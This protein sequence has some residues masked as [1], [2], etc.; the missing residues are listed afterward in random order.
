LAGEKYNKNICG[1]AY[2]K[3][4]LFPQNYLL[5]RYFFKRKAG[6]DKKEN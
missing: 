4:L 6:K 2:K 5:L 3:F 1:P